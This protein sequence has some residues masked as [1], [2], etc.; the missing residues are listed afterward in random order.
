MAQVA[1]G[2]VGGVVG[3]FFGNPFM[4]FSI[5]M[6]LGGLLFPPD[7]GTFESG[8]LSDVRVQAASYGSS[9]PRVYGRHRLA[10]SLV[11]ASNWEEVSSSSGGGKKGGPTVVTYGYYADFAILICRGEIFKVR[12]IWANTEVIYED[13]PESVGYTGPIYHRTVGPDNIEIYSGSQTQNP[14]SRMEEHLGVGNTPAYRGSAYV[15]FKDYRVDPGG[16]LPNFTFEIQS[17]DGTIYLDEVAGSLYDSLGGDS[18]ED[19]DFSAMSAVAVE[20]LLIASENDARGV[21]HSLEVA[22][23][24]DMV[25]ADGQIKA[26]P[27]GGAAIETIP[28]ELMGAKAGAMGDPERTHLVRGQ[29]PESPRSVTITY[30]SESRDFNNGSQTGTRQYGSSDEGEKIALP[31]VLSDDAAATVAFIAVHIGWLQRDGYNFTLPLRYLFLAPADVLIVP[32]TFGSMTLRIVEMGLNLMGEV[33]LLAVEEEP[34]L[35]SIVANGSSGSGGG[36]VIEYEPTEMYAFDTVA[37]V[38]ENADTVGFYVAG[39]GGGAPWPGAQV[40]ADPDLQSPSLYPM[41]LVADL[42]ERA[43]IGLTVGTLAAGV[44]HV[45]DNVTAL[46]V[47]F[48]F[49]SPVAKT[50]LEVLNGANA[51]VVGQELLQFCNVTHLT[52]TTYRLTKLLRGR[53]GSEWAVGIHGA[54]EYA[55][56]LGGL[57]TKRVDAAL[58]EIGALHNYEAVENGKVYIS[59]DVPFDQDLTIAGNSRKPLSPVHV[60]GVT[61]LVNSDWEIEWKRRARKQGGWNDFSDVALDEPSEVYDLII[62]DTGMVQVREVLGLT[63]PNYTY[64]EADQ[65]TD[66]GDVIDDFRAVV[67]M[68]SP[69][70]GR[71]FASDP[72]RIYR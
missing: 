72:G 38:D 24:F 56:L 53:R 7:Q 40:F 44:T 36:G 28:A 2:I 70:V 58:T 43:T 23:T 60:K 1:L 26:V 34:E 18:A 4:G 21:F 33:E 42:T 65:T 61:S 62:Y 17:H 63:S 48:K 50:E 52:G 25:E 57:S 66:F 29:E 19:L 67:Y 68:V 14:D 51:M 71:G 3:S 15:M 22:Y 32:N 30:P 54:A 20:G 47:E 46:D 49:G 6:T 8:R 12:R 64:L 39:A 37:L 41:D 59:P 5:G 13:R 55:I 27:R 69:I 45:W 9:I 31:V 11:W 16:Q 35:Y 10:G